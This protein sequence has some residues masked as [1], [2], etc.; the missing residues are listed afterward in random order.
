MLKQVGTQLLIAGGVGFGKTLE[1]AIRDLPVGSIVRKT[2][3]DATL[4][5]GPVEHTIEYHA[6]LDHLNREEDCRRAWEFFEEQV[7]DA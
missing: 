7:E 6:T 4:S 2:S 3:P 5:G 1:A